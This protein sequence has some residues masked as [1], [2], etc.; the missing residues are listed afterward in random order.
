MD[1]DTKYVEPSAFGWFITEH[2]AESVDSS[3]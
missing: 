2:I 1:P 3:I